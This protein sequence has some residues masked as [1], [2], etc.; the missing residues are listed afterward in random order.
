LSTSHST[1]QAT[2]AE[3]PVPHRSPVFATTQWT[4]VLSA[5]RNDTL[6]R[7]AL[8]RLCET[9]W[10][11][12]YSYVRRRNFS[13]PDAEDLTQEFFARFLE[14]RWVESA[15]RDKGRFRT[16]LLTALN[17]FL[18]NEWHKANAR[19][20]GGGAK[21]L[22]LQF[23]TAETRY[24]REPADNT[25]PEQHFEKRWALTLLEQV[26]TRLG[27]EYEKDGK[28][29]L[30]QILHPCLI[31]DRTSQPYESI[32]AALGTSEGAVKS[33]VHRLR[34]RYRQLL[35]DEIA[36]TVSDPTL[37]DVELRHLIGVLGS[38]S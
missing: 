29:Q 35:R 26:I 3:S 21:I 23:D 19:K 20:R 38:A 31:G 33:A 34:Q 30:F 25:T 22:P 7:D 37:V 1:K 10:Y 13:A 2:T 8:A 28:Q 24:V 27:R 4:V 5:G 32:A 36:Q 9:Y 11:P 14:H 16:F 15:D 12:L 6:A 18:A 17:H